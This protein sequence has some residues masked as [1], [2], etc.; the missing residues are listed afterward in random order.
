MGTKRRST[1]VA[2]SPDFTGLDTAGWVV[3]PG[4][5]T[6]AAARGLAEEC[7]TTLAA[8]DDDVRVGDKQVSGTRR[9]V[10]LVD[11]LPAVGAVVGR[12]ELRAA[13][14]WFLGDDFTLGGVTFRSAEPGF[15]EQ[16]FHADAVPLLAPGPW[17][18][19]TAI[20]ALCDF[21]AD[22]GATAVI[23]GSHRRPDLQRRSGSL[24]DHPDELVLT[25][26]AG[27]AFVFCGHLL[28]RGTRNRSTE[29]RPA[30]QVSWGRAPSPGRGRA[31]RGEGGTVPA[32]AT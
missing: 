9:L 12:P 4:V 27:T 29:P 10:D 24:G 13:V 23:P 7:R 1:P 8:I 22:N 18:V 30:L 2:D 5:L 3:G 6:D 14:A 15:G 20:I 31:P 25:G 32:A 21:T 17:Q 26:P 19:V 16:R 28:H 11:R